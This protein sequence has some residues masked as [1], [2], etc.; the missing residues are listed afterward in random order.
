MLQAIRRRRFTAED[1]FR[2]QASSCGIYGRQSDAGS[3]FFPENFGFLSANV[4]FPMIH[5]DIYC[6]TAVIGGAR[7]CSG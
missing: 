1:L 4:I 7:W 5:T 3:D 2:S 6:N